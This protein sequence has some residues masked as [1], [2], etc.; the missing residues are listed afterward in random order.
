MSKYEWLES[1]SARVKKIDI[2]IIQV[3]APVFNC[4]IHIGLEHVK[5]KRKD[6]FEVKEKLK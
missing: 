2:S 5:F 1:Y 4:K 3:T 6:K